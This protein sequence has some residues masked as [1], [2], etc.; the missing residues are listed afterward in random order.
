VAKETGNYDAGGKCISF[1]NN[2]KICEYVRIGSL[3]LQYQPTKYA[4]LRH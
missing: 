1:C 2:E 3:N 4:S